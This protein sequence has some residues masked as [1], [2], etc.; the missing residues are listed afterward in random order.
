MVPGDVPTSGHAGVGDDV[1]NSSAW[2]A[3]LS[4]RERRRAPVPRDAATRAR[5]AVRLTAWRTDRAVTGGLDPDLTRWQE[6]GLGDE[7]LWALLGE[8]PEEIRGR[9]PQPP[10]WLTAVTEAYSAG[11]PATDD[12]PIAGLGPTAGL[13]A[14]TQP[15]TSW[16]QRALREDLNQ[17]VRAFGGRDDIPTDHPLLRLNHELHLAM[18]SPVLA[19]QLRRAGRAGALSGDTPSARFADFVRQLREPAY[20]LRILAEHPTLA[21]ELVHE[22]E[23]WRNVRREL[24][25]RVL[26]DLPALRA[27]FGLTGTGLHNLVEVLT[28]AGDTHRGGR[29]VAILVFADGGRVVYKP[30]DL[31][32]ESHFYA[33]V[34]WLN[35]KGLTVALRRLG[36]L[37]RDGYGWVEFAAAGGCTGVDAVRRFFWRQGAYLGL[38]YLLRASD[39]HLENIIAAG[40]D[41][42]IVDL[43]ATF[44]QVL[45]TVRPQPMAAPAEALTL[46]EESVLAIGLLPRRMMRLD[47]DSVIATE[48]SGMAGG[49]TGE[50]S[51]MPMPRWQDAGTDRMRRI[52]T[53][54]EMPG[55]QNLPTSDGVAVD[56]TD[57]RDDL[58]AGFESCYR[59]L[60]AHR[61]ELAAAD[62]PLAAFAADEIRVIVLPTMVYGRILGES[63]HPVVLGDAL[64]RECLFEV[65]AGRHPDLRGNGP[66]AES[67]IRQITRRDI[68]FFWTRPDSRH[69]YDDHGVVVR[70]FFDRSGLDLVRDRVAGLC[71]ADLRRQSWT[72]S[73]SL[74]ALEIGDGQRD[75]RPRVRDLP[76]EEINQALAGRAAVRLGDQLL[77]TA[78]GDPRRPVWLT[79]TLVADR[80]WTVTPSAFE[81]FSGLCGI[82]V[83]LGQ[84]GEQ[85]GLSRFRTSAEAIARMLGEHVD[86]VLGW[87]DADR[88]AVGIGAGLTGLGGYLHTLTHL[89]ALWGSG[90]LLA[91]AHRLVPEVTRRVA[92]DRD[93]DVITGTAGAAL[94][95]RALH[96]VDPTDQTLAAL[97]AAGERLLTTATTDDRGLTW[98]PV[99]ETRAPLLG[100]SHG[101]S[102]IALALAEIA[103]VTGE[104]RFLDAAEKAVRYEH[105][106]YDAAAGNWPDHRSISP[107]GSFMN[108]WCHGAAGIGLA[109]TEMLGHVDIPEVRVDLDRAVATVRRDLLHDGRLTGIGNDCLCHGDLGLVETLLSAGAVTGD[110][111]LS[112]L[113][114]RIARAVAETVLAGEELCGVPQGLH[115][116]GLLMGTAGIGYGLLRAARPDLVPNVLLLEPPAAAPPPDG[117]IPATTDRVDIE[118]AAC[119]AYR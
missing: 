91:Q 84:L 34:D 94:A 105:R 40:E 114:R 93:L 97:A 83:F 82:A 99:L 29:S 75:P 5:G 11:P 80:Y 73:A 20:A 12:G 118:E 15:L 116:P 63:W 1:L 61:D 53:R 18:T 66:V 70:D 108:T 62:G 74:A 113:A 55:G 21:G 30:R 65:I 8:S 38:L 71:D 57:Y 42:V 89:G 7:D 44:Q 100:F 115:V 35:S 102:G 119:P 96:T 72:V 86:A 87:S 98:H 79:L 33:L 85:T 31:A 32:V 27:E 45:P 90:P 10:A 19:V 24:A 88:E 41:P 26:A 95:L 78:V 25:E 68:P 69:L 67:E 109:R 58:I 59:L 9:L 39:M 54:V 13:L 81:S 56:P 51:P 28:G 106:Q 101:V 77:E 2:W 23:T 46:T 112:G 49:K 17:L 47:G 22:L 111:T 14:L 107:E 92:G 36:I 43:E 37:E 110:D 64:D 60:L 104:R 6:S 4:L 48:M 52:R 103:R 50:L 3:A 16:F 117:P 76:P